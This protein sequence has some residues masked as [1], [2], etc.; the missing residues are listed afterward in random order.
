MG[1][2]PAVSGK[3][4]IRLLI[5]DGWIEGR[6]ATHGMTLTKKFGATTRVT[7]VPDKKAILPDGTLHAI[8]GSKQTQL[9]RKG[10]ERMIKKY[11]LKR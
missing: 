8:L 9:G 1:N 2:L 5:S 4:L 3:Q 11:G 7:F 6:R 10:L